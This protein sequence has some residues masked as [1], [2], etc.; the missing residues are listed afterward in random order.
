MI[1]K[2]AIISFAATM[3]ESLPIDEV[4]DDNISVPL[5]SMLT[6]FLVFGH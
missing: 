6:A 2:V 1:K 5:S 3:V 4:V